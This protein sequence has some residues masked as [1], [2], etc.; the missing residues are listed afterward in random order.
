MIGRL[1]ENESNP[2]PVPA[3]LL[4]LRLAVNVPAWLGVPEIT[5]LV[6]LI[7]SP[8]GS[9]FAPKLVALP[10]AVTVKVNGTPTVPSVVSALV[11][12]KALSV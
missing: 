6:G 7:V 9:P 8:G 3:A 5:P 4:T 11:M 1:I 10:V 2:L 12:V